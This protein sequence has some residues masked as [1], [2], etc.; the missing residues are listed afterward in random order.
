MLMRSPGGRNSSTKQV[1]TPKINRE[2]AFWILK[3][4]SSS[5]DKE[6]VMASVQRRA[7]SDLGLYIICCKSSILILG[8]WWRWVKFLFH[9]MPPCHPHHLN[10]LA[11]SKVSQ[12]PNRAWKRLFLMIKRACLEE[13]SQP[14]LLNR[15]GMGW[16]TPKKFD[17]LEKNWL[18]LH[19]FCNHF[20][21]CPHV[22]CPTVFFAKIWGG[23][24]KPKLLRINQPRDFFPSSI[25]L[26]LA[27]IRWES[28]LNVLWRYFDDRF[29]CKK[30]PWKELRTLNLQGC[31]VQ[32]SVRLETRSPL[33]LLSL[34][35]KYMNH[36]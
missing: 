27:E 29:S 36:F 5:F 9:H 12:G 2:I 24:H 21:F 35:S 18:F 23:N 13:I 28:K 19:G 17:H 30:V 11:S 4:H 26:L 34:L 3:V 14:F 22:C 25:E 10:S 8:W 31:Y 16:C 6:T 15:M 1:T 7:V 33:S 20:V 32:K